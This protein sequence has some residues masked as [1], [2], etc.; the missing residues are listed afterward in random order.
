MVCAVLHYSWGASPGESF[1][2]IDDT[3][4]V[5]GAAVSPERVVQYID[6]TLDLLS[7]TWSC[8]VSIMGLS[9]TIYP[10]R[11]HVPMIRLLLFN[12]N[13]I[14]S[15]VESLRVN[16]CVKDIERYIWGSKPTH[17][18]R[19]GYWPCKARQVD[20]SIRKLLLYWNPDCLLCDM[21]LEL[22][23]SC[24]WSSLT[25][26][27]QR[28]NIDVFCECFLCCREGISRTINC[29]WNRARKI[30]PTHSLVS[31]LPWK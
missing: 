18:V 29:G 11:L 20:T 30:P 15:Y 24:W 31:T 23:A 26:L 27:L 22:T 13:L 6:R 10:C 9:W 14:F 19:D 1:E 25:V 8:A 4:V 7:L 28:T 5:G 12:W 3:W 2:D 17:S 21:S 16:I